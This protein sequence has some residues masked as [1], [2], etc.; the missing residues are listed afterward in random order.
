MYKDIFNSI[1]EEIVGSYY[2]HATNGITYSWMVAFFA[3]NQSM[4]MET[5]A[6]SVSVEEKAKKIKDYVFI[7][8]KLLPVA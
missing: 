1:P 8:P 5:A 4:R 2:L 3:R 7:F 6:R